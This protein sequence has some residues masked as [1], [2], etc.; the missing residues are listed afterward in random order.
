LDLSDLVSDGVRDAEDEE[1]F[2]SQSPFKKVRSRVE[3]PQVNQPP[4]VLEWIRIAP[5]SS[6]CE[7]YILKI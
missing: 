6:S 1:F 5:E 3:A 2:K 7:L 4:D